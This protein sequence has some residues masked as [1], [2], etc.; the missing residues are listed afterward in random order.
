MQHFIDIYNTVV[1]E[2]ANKKAIIDDTYSYTYTELD[3]AAGKVY[4]YLKGQDIGTEDFVQLVMP[5]DARM[6]AALIGVLKAGAAFIM[7][8]A[9]YPPER[10]EFIYKDCG[11]KLR[12]G[13]EQFDDI[14]NKYDSLMGNVVTNPHD[15]CY[16]VYTSGSTGTP[17]G[18]LHEYGN[19]DQAYMPYDTDYDKGVEISA[20]FAPFYFVATI[21]DFTHFISKGRTIYIVPH[22]TTRDFIACNKFIEDNNIQEMFMP[23]SF[24]RMYLSPGKSLPKCLKVVVTGSEPANGLTFNNNP[25]LINKYA[26]SESGFNVLQYSLDK[27]YDVAPVGKQVVDGIDVCIIDD[28]GNV[29]EGTGEG[30]LCFINEFVRGYINLPEQTAKAWKDGLYHSNDLVRRDE[31]GKCF[32]VGRFDDMIKIN[33]NRVEPVEIETQVKKLTG[34]NQ[35]FAKGFID[36]SRSY[37][38]VYYLNSEAEDKGLTE[39]GELAIDKEALKKL[40]PDYMIPAYYIGLDKF[41][42]TPTGKVSRRLL[43]APDTSDY[44][45]EYIE[46]VGDIEKLLCDKMAE[47]LKLDRVSVIDDFYAL[48]G[49]SMRSMAFVALCNEAGVNVTS[50]ILYDYKTPR[51]MAKHC[52][53]VISEAELNRLNEEA[54]GKRWQLLPSQKANIGFG[55]KNDEEN[56]FNLTTLCRLKDDVDVDRLVKACNKVFKAHS[57]MHIRITKED[58]FYQEYDKTFVPDTSI[59]ELG[60]SEFRDKM[61]ELDRPYRIYKEKFYRCHVYKTEEG[62]YFYLNIHHVISDGTSRRLILEQIA[63]AYEDAAYEVPKDYY[64]YMLSKRFEEERGEKPLPEGSA[65]HLVNMDRDDEGSEGAVVFRQDI[66]PVDENRDGSFFVAAL[67]MAIARYNGR[68]DVRIKEVFSGRDEL[69]TRNIA[70]ELAISASVDAHITGDMTFDEVREEI[71]EKEL[72][73]S[74]HPINIFKIDTNGKSGIRFNYQKGTTD[75]GAFDELVAENYDKPARDTSM[76]GTFSLNIIER[77]GKDTVDALMAYAKANYNKESIVKLMDMFEEIVRENL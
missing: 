57:G 53:Y 3:E 64:F 6:L 35:I 69:Y 33:G 59:I 10:I 38:C 55:W 14:M 41:P 2:N 60:E 7:L 37:I 28:E 32:L 42:L 23:P 45:R 54:M 49:D 31:E 5:R 47:V 70:G 4:A 40:L 65:I 39:G 62:N 43:E 44:K 71:R 12:L 26:M 50:G 1:Q 8:E 63:E 74:T 77:D 20:M 67:A 75:M 27:K 30:E 22:D 11:V 25:V 17:K 52:D 66:A 76:H 18:V 24:L 73:E 56:A 13:A 48:G 9:T 46:P 16:A 15:A 21:L 19:L 29:V 68:E 36:E 72:Y 61:S 58:Q 51:D 34:L